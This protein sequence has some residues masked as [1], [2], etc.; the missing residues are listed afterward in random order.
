MGMSAS[1][2]IAWGIIVGGDDGHE[3]PG[4]VAE[5]LKEL[6]NGDWELKKLFGFTDDHPKW[7]ADGPRD[8]RNPAWQEWRA[9]CDAWEARKDAA[10]PVAFDH[11]GTYDYGTYDYGGRALIVKR[12]RTDVN[13]G[14]TAVD[15]ADLTAEPAVTNLQQWLLPITA[16]V[17]VLSMLIAAGKTRIVI[18][19]NVRVRGNGTYAGFED[20]DGPIAVG[21]DVQ[22]YEHES[23]LVGKGRVTE[24]D[25]ERE[26]VYLSVDWPSLAATTTVTSGSAILSTQLLY[27][28]S[29][30]SL[31]CSAPGRP[32]AP[33]VTHDATPGVVS[34]YSDD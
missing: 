32:R 8:T 9:A 19:P 34:V 21:E 2:T 5:A 16:A 18:D 7:T 25:R 23:G 24:I 1:A 6:D 12:T 13:W 22:V 28:P 17:A 14:I 29:M 20:V 10:V 3:L 11:Y 31:S 33:G 30:P 15:L 26:L 27:L 4:T